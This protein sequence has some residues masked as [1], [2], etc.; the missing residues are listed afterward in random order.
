M[1]QRMTVPST[2]DLGTLLLTPKPEAILPETTRLPLLELRPINPRSEWFS[3]INPA[4][5]VFAQRCLTDEEVIL[6][7]LHR[8]P[9]FAEM[10]PPVP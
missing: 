9:P 10:L 2:L 8:T 5:A 1:P 7:T 3:Q 4:E 6:P